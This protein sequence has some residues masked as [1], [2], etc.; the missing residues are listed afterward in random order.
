MN[1]QDLGLKNK[2]ETKYFSHGHISFST[3]NKNLF[4]SIT[5]WSLDKSMQSKI[6][7]NKE[8]KDITHLNDILA[9]KSVAQAVEDSIQ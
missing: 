8:V 7:E 3:V 5:V 9:I 4:Y 1:L 2:P 6:V